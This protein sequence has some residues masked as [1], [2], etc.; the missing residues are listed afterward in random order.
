MLLLLLHAGLC[1][2]PGKAHDS[3]IAELPAKIAPFFRPPP[4]FAEDYGDY[5]PVLKFNDGSPV[6]TPA[7][8]Q[9]RRAEILETWRKLIGSWPPLI[10]KPKIE[11]LAKEQRE[12]LTQH[13]VSIE[14]A[15]NQQTVMGYLLVPDGEG[16]FPAVLVVYYD[17]ET[18]AGL[19]RQAN[20]GQ[21]R[22][23]RDFGLQLTRRGF[24]TLSI[25]TPDFCSLRPPYKPLYDSGEDQPQLQPLSALAYVA[26]N[27]YN[28]LANRPEVDPARIGIVGHSYGGKWAMFA[29]CLYDK[30][31]CAV[32]S[33]PGI[34]FDETRP[35][36]NYWEPWYLG[37]GPDKQRQRG[38]PSESNPRTGP[39]KKLL[40]QR[41][42]LH[43]LHALMAPRPF[44]V[45]G[46]SEDPPQRWEALN[47]TVAVNKLLGF[48]D[49]VAMTN[50]KGHTPTP[51]S[52]EQIYLFFEHFL[53]RMNP[54]TRAATVRERY[55]TGSEMPL[56]DPISRYNLGW[57][58]DLKWS[59][60]VSIEDFAGSSM[61]ARLEAAQDAVIARGGGVVNVSINHGHIF[62]GQNENR[63]AGRNCLVYACI[64]RN[65][66]LI[67]QRFP[68]LSIGQHLWHRFTK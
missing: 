62:F 15:P 50:R 17:A 39:Y 52:N 3:D 26:A 32:W 49:R 41:H 42:D 46:G 68:G 34:V 66:A 7:D 47:H 37:Y 30:F 11:Y 20:G 25:G 24:V 28:C 54:A 23:L 13:Q 22:E 12:K 29:S 51:E 55:I 57:T 65:A 48:S 16:P 5:R 53:K 59:N 61:S 33:D 9:K 6:K 27:C 38:V 58:N 56:D 14:I 18:G 45:S 36:V 64:L 44:L 35:N 19:A 40:E 63:Q 1:S 60:V 31:A 10:D 21:G 67:D 8:W 2:Q 43:E 4:E